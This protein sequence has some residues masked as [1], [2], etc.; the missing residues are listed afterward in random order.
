MRI[1][2]GYASLN[3]GPRKME[4]FVRRLYANLRTSVRSQ[5]ALCTLVCVHQ[6]DL[7][8]ECTK[9]ARCWFETRTALYKYSDLKKIPIP[10]AEHTNLLTHIHRLGT[11]FVR[12]PYDIWISVRYPYD[13][14]TILGVHPAYIRR[15]SSTAAAARASSLCHYRCMWQGEWCEASRPLNYRTTCRMLRHVIAL[16]T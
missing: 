13:I 4:P 10:A 12:Y 7:G 14:R 1:N 5:Y 9:F 8:T 6:Y 11:K 15:T 2:S 16:L 3:T